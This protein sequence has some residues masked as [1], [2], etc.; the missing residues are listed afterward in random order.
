VIDEDYSIVAVRKRA[1]K[2]AWHL[3]CNLD[4]GEARAY[5]HHR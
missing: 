2:L 1:P 4:A 5:D 3:G